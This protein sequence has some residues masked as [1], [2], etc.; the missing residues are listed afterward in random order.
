M[1]KTIYAQTR[2]DGLSREEFVHR[3]RRHG[4]LAMSL[5]G[6]WDPVVRYI[7]SDRLA[8]VSAFP[9]ASSTYVGIGEIH[10]RDVAGRRAS[11]QSPELET[12]LFP[13]ASQLFRRQDSINIGVEEVFL[14]RG[15]Y[16]PIKI[17]AFVA[18]APATSQRS[19]FA[20]WEGLQERILAESSSGHLVRRL[21]IGRG[22]EDDADR[23]GT[24]EI[25][26]DTIAEAQEFYGNWSERVGVEA[27][28]LIRRE[29]LVIVPA[30][31]S[32]FYDRRFYE[33]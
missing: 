14:F 12:T 27:T 26:F 7:Q 11:K 24:V 2:L 20:D 4:A 21:V 5:P 9:S 18:R 33:G 30:F 19:F 1:I 29:R 15:R 17:Y 16:A 13:D 28:G 3:W 8:D 6:F 32:L 31:V 25:S 22:L 23:D 10:Y